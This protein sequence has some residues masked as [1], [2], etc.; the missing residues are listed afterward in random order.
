MIKYF[1]KVIQTNFVDDSESGISKNNERKDEINKN[2]DIN[3]DV[4]KPF[5]NIK[6]NV[7]LQDKVI[8]NNLDNSNVLTNEMND[9]LNLNLKYTNKQNNND[10]NV[11]LKIENIDF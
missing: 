11:Q 1:Y 5:I 7:L 8:K 3:D 10:N 9:F 6:E 2:K 4:N